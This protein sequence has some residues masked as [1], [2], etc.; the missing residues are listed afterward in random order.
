MAVDE[1]LIKGAREASKGPDLSKGWEEISKFSNKLLTD[2]VTK[3]KEE[4]KEREDL[5]TAYE[6]SA[7]K[8]Y[9]QAGSLGER[10]F[11]IA[12]EATAKL[13]EKYH[14]AV[15][16]GNKKEQAKLL[17]ELNS[18]S[19]NMQSLKEV[20]NTAAELIKPSDGTDSTISAGQTTRQKAIADAIMDG[21]TARM[22][23]KGEWEWDVVID[24]KKETVMSEDLMKSLPIKD[25]KSIKALKDLELSMLEKG[26]LFQRGEGK[27]I[28]APELLDR[29]VKA[30]EAHITE[31]NIMSLVHDDI[32]DG[33][34]S[35]KQALEVHPEIINITNN[36]DLKDIK[37]PLEEGEE[38]WYDNISKHDKE[39]MINALTN[40]ENEFYD[41]ETTRGVLAGYIVERQKREFFGDM[42]KYENGKLVLKNIKP[43]EGETKESFLARGGII[44]GEAVKWVVDKTNPNKGAFEVHQRQ[45]D[46]DALV[47]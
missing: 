19:T 36:P 33:G 31:D 42:A 28:F 41:H 32:H 22:N 40:P 46:Y 16:S 11:D 34:Y 35:F 2:V 30:T 5:T 45:L 25:E 6:A 18:Y 3:R 8:I 4:K 9:A 47:E 12:Y 27:D 38:N 37:L 10:E 39:L 23:D 44:D 15:K 24:G 21:S 14:A 43:N 29:Q 26:A 7:E 17:A 1:A 20:Y 13:Q